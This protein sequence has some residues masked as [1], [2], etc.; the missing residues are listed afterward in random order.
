MPFRS[1]RFSGN[2]R[3]ETAAM[4]N[5]PF[6]KGASGDGVAV[7]Q[8]ALVD[9]GYPMPITTAWSGKA[10]GIYGDETVKSVSEFQKD[11]GLSR[12][13]VAGRDTITRLDAIFAVIEKDERLAR[14][15][16]DPR[17]WAVSTARANS[18]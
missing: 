15:P 11:E 7:V 13:G 6:H 14:I 2:P 4:N 16:P 17:N 18:V 5:P 12:D 10:D 1:R 8:Q 9:L 3:L